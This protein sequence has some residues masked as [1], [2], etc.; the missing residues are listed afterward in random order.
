MLTMPRDITE[1]CRDSDI[2]LSSVG[3]AEGTSKLSDGV[4]SFST[5]GSCRDPLRGGGDKEVI[6]GNVT[7][8]S[9]NNGSLRSALGSMIL[10]VMGVCICRKLGSS[11]CCVMCSPIGVVG[12][13]YV[14]PGSW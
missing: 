14:W 13:V 2:G 3:V 5:R 10:G 9:G 6:S 4:S 1:P 8:W 12:G 7:V 11:W